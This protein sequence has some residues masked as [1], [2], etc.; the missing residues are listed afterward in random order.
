[1][2]S[3]ERGQEVTMQAA[4]KLLLGAAIA[5]AGAGALCGNADARAV[6]YATVEPPV[7]RVETV[8]PP[9]VGYV[10]VQGYWGWGHGRYR[11]HHGHWVRERRGYHY[12]P[13]R[14]DR[15]GHRWRYHEGRWER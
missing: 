7:L 11:W 10:W 2:R 9:R 12:V 1:M 3:S 5:L 6:I 15:D 14:W 8:P 4:R 13:S